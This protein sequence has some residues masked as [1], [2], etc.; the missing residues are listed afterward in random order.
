MRLPSAS[1]V[2][3]AGPSSAGQ[4]RESRM[5]SIAPAPRMVDLRRCGGAPAWEVGEGLGVGARGRVRC[6]R[7]DKEVLF[8]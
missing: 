8:F 4:E 1:P 5:R 7:R 2:M 3:L 6:V